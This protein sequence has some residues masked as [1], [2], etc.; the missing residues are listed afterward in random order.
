MLFAL[1]IGAACNQ[2]DSPPEPDEPDETKR[3]DTPDIFIQEKIFIAESDIHY[4]KTDTVLTGNDVFISTPKDY[5]SYKWWIGREDQF[6]RGRKIEIYF[7]SPVR[8]KVRLFGTKK[9]GKTDT[10][11]RFLTVLN[12]PFVSL[13][14]TTPLIDTFKGYN[15]S[16]PSHK[17][18]VYFAKTQ[19]IGFPDP[20]LWFFN[21]P[22]GCPRQEKVGIVNISIGFKAMVFQSD[23]GG[24]N[25]VYGWAYLQDNR[26][27]IRA[28]YEMYKYPDSGEAIRVSKTFIGTKL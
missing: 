10:L 5:E 17:F 11:S 16:N 23:D 14:N 20:Q 27:R 18:K 6:R 7:T 2:D 1:A 19:P 28:E 9:N 22:E 4:S 15:K 13:N 3:I 25:G 24:C 26:R 8:V 21:L 12:D